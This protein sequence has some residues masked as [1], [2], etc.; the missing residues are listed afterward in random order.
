VKQVF[1]KPLN[2]QRQITNDE[3]AFD[4]FF[5]PNK[6]GH[7]FK[8]AFQHT[9]ALFNFPKSMVS[10]HHLFRRKGRIAVLNGIRTVELFIDLRLFFLKGNVVILQKGELDDLPSFFSS[11]LSW[12]LDSTNFFDFQ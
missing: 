5:R 1:Q 9:K 8:I 7:G 2:D 11:A 12:D 6:D 4:A 3:M 10:F